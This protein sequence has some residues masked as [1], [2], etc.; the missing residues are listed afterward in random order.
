M[1]HFLKEKSCLIAVLVAATFPSHS[2]PPASLPGQPRQ[3]TLLTNQSPVFKD[4]TDSTSYELGVK[5]SPS[6]NGVVTAIRYWK[7]LS[8]LGVPPP[9]PQTY[10]HTGRIWSIQP[11]ALAGC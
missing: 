10:T 1:K 8:E 9:A 7:P 2:A 4:A 6:R 11:S 3:Q 5:F